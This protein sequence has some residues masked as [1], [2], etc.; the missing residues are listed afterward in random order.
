MRL[1]GD[2]LTKYDD[3]L[4]EMMADGIR[5]MIYAGDLDLICNYLGNRRCVMALHACTRTLSAL[6]S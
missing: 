5:I 2:W 1:P 4:P 3:I 6:K